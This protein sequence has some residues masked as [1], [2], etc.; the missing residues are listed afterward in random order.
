MKKTLGALC[1]FS[2][3]TL[4][5]VACQDAPVDEP[6]IDNSAMTTRTAGD[7]ATHYYWYKG[8]KVPLTLNTEYVNV[9]V[10][11]NLAKSANIQSLAQRYN[12]A[13]ND[14]DQ[15][16]NIIKFKLTSKAVATEYAE[17]TTDLKRNA[18]IKQV[19]PFFD[20]KDAE[21]IGTSDIFYLKLK[22]ADDFAIL[23]ALAEKQ[24]VLI[25]KEVPN[26]PLWYILS[27]QDSAFE[28]SVAASNYFYETGKFDAVDPAFMFDFQ[29][30]AVPND[31]MFNQ[32]WGLKNNSY[33]GIDINATAAWDLTKG[34]GVKVAV[35]DQGI[36]PD[37]NDLKANF[38]A[39]SYDAQRG[40]SPSVFVSSNEHG[41]HVA[42][43]VAAVWNNNLQ[44]V[45][46][47][48]ES[49]IMRVSH[50]LYISNTISSEL[51]SG[52]SWAW[53]NGADVITNSWGDQG[54]SFYSQMHSTI[55]EQAITDAMTKG[56]NGLGCVVTFA[57][58]NSPG[59]MDYPGNFH[60]DILTVGSINSDGSKSSFSGYGSKL[61]VVAPGNNILSTVPG[62][63]T[64]TKNGTS[65]ATPHVAGIAA[66]IIAKNPTFTRSQVVTAIEKSAKKVG[67]YTYSTTSG[68]SNGTWNNQ[69]GY[70]LVDAYAA[71]TN[72]CTTVTFYDQNVTT[73]R[74][75]QGCEVET[76]NVT[77]SNSA[78]LMIIGSK[79]V[80]SLTTLKVNSGCKF[81]IRSE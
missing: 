31:P 44:V 47:A 65:M 25:T 76:K 69:M 72:G 51:A 23:Q 14:S 60:D 71:L 55:L 36:D 79:K 52:I 20:R 70:G 63:K 40:T 12:L 58:G 45:G 42:G 6:I 49:K 68:R 10:D 34:A 54:G 27:I 26:M 50:D 74:T 57:A 33:S 81:E 19:L 62:N 5:M 39:L 30:N 3:L 16:G 35:V 11:D 73:D 21:P 18:Q 24:N 46:V 15:V 64:K 8:E 48:P 61:D 75:V 67:G 43:T 13:Q 2:L 78:R 4:T 66:L 17:L 28:S 80:T 37:H 41:T 56:R 1:I 77:V 59:V 38:H 7:D 22:T 32:L 9:I 53:K 29:P